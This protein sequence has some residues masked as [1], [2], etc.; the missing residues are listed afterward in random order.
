MHLPVIDSVKSKVFA[1]S[2]LLIA[3]VLLWYSP[4]VII[5]ALGLWATYQYLSRKLSAQFITTRVLLFITSLF[6]YMGILCLL[7]IF[8]AAVCNA[9]LTLVTVASLPVTFGLLLYE[10]L[11]NKGQVVR[12]KV[13][14]RSDIVGIL[15]SAIV[16]LAIFFIPLLNNNVFSAHSNILVLATG[17]VDFST[18]LGLYNDYIDFGTVR[19]WTHPAEVRGVLDGFYPSS[20]H[21]ANALVT[22]L[23]YPDIKPGVGSAIAFILLH[24]FW[25]G[26]LV[27]IMAKLAFSTYSHWNRSQ[28]KLLESISISLCIGV[29][30]YFFIINVARLGFFSYVPQ[31]ISALLLIYMLPQLHQDGLGKKSVMAISIFFCTLSLATWVLLLPVLL[32]SILGVLV[33]AAIKRKSSW[34]LDQ[35]SADVKGNWPLYLVAAIGVLSQARLISKATPAT[36]VSFIQ[37]ILLNGGAPR[38]DPLLYAVLF[39]GLAVA[40]YLATKRK[41]NAAWHD[42]FTYMAASTLLFVFLLFALQTYLT[43]DLHYYY[44]KSLLL[45]C[46]TLTPVAAA[47]A[48]TLV[49]TIKRKDKLLALT[50]SVCLPVSLIM[51]IP[52]DASVMSYIHGTSTVSASLNQSIYE[53]IA[54][55]QANR[56]TLYL[57]DSIIPSDVATLLAQSN[58][59][60]NQC[61]TDLRTE[62]VYAPDFQKA[63]ISLNDNKLPASCKNKRVEVVIDSKNKALVNASKINKFSVSTIN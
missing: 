48:A 23:I 55:P 2:A 34:R 9:S 33:S 12:R 11:Y 37:G 29:A 51:F 21:A 57:V 28:P 60:H 14:D 25:I 54:K 24:V 63:I 4:A 41:L 7:V 6:S 18:H 39:S 46:I 17:N 38:Y 59:P 44:F 42:T 1:C 8:F 49:K 58:R 15:L 31:L 45:L 3:V 36:S 61:V 10:V 26:V 13:F 32:G 16:L 52:S 20:W 19:P 56:V 50:A 62:K 5:A 43:G 47:M 27:F 53:R 35:A 22:K 30:I 40:L